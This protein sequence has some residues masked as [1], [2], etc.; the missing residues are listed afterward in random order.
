MW[1]STTELLY[2]S[3][4]SLLTRVNSFQNR[5]IPPIL[6]ELVEN[7]Y[8]EKQADD[9]INEAD[10]V[11]QLMEYVTNFMSSSNGN[12]FFLVIVKIQN[13]AGKSERPNMTFLVRFV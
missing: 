7:L 9:D 1:F 6:C 5:K 13:S 12:Y 2:H 3:C 4:H 8:A 10:E 11:M